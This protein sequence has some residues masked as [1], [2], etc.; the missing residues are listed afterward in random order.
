[1]K[2]LKTSK[3]LTRGIWGTL[4]IIV[5][6]SYVSHV[7][8]EQHLLELPSNKMI[9]LNL[10]SGAE[11]NFEVWEKQQVEIRYED[12]SQ[13]LDNYQIEIGENSSGLNISSKAPQ[14]GGMQLSFELKVPQKTQLCLS[15][16]GGNI[17]AS[18]LNGGIAVCDA[19]ANYNDASVVIHSKGG[20]VHVASARQGANVQT[21]GGDISVQDAARYVVA[22]TGGGDINVQ[23]DNGAVK[24]HTG[25]G[26]IEVRI[27]NETAQSG[28]IELITGLGDVWLFVPKNY[29]MNLAVE[30]AYTAD[31][32]GDYEVDSD[33]P[34]FLAASDKLSS[35]GT[36]R[37]YLHGTA[38]L[39]DGQHRVQIKTTN[40]NVYIREI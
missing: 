6:L 39:N 29:S 26:E 37:K 4:T 31:T 38:S 30:I 28:D 24:A 34:I 16:S 27:L 14:S 7:I 19:S 13:N 18:G 1:M 35:S 20:H 33:F 15:S 36:A 32:N 11:I 10:Q 3:A 9:R 40:G 21:A 17:S 25:A 22:D 8:A 23:L 12:P 2:L 5:S